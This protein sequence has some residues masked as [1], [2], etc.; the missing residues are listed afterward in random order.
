MILIKAASTPEV[1]TNTGVEYLF[2]LSLY[3]SETYESHLV[4]EKHAVE[5][6]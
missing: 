2:N 3:C 6:I 1:G 5:N 4:L